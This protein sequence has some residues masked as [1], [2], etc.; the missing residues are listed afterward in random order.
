MMIPKEA[1][2]A[3][4]SLEGLEA[5][6]VRMRKELAVFRQL[7]SE[8]NDILREISESLKKEEA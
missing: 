3:L 1:K 5:E 2:D 4:H 6:V 7:L 8:Q